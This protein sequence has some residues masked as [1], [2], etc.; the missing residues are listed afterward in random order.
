[1]LFRRTLFFTFVWVAGKGG[2]GPHLPLLSSAS[3]WSA[4]VLPPFSLSALA[5]QVSETQ[6]LSSAQTG[7]QPT[8]SP[9]WPLEFRVQNMSHYTWP[10]L[11]HFGGIVESADAQNVLSF[12]RVCFLFSTFLQYWLSVCPV[13]GE[14]QGALTKTWSFCPLESYHDSLVKYSLC[15]YLYDVYSFT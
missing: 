15:G 9:P 3:S 6:S 11:W 7:L 1:M 8:Q 14:R 13:L 12:L 2:A 5:L 10:W 4:W